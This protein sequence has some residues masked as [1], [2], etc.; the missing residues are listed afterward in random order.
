MKT[1]GYIL[2][3][4]GLTGLSYLIGNLLMGTFQCN[5]ATQLISGWIGAIVVCVVIV[6]LFLLWMMFS[7]HNIDFEQDL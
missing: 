5:L 4:L 2:I 3:L 1:I 6:L 7:D